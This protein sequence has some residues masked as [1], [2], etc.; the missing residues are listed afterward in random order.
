[1][2]FQDIIPSELEVGEGEDVLVGEGE[3]EGE[4]VLVGEGEGE[5]EFGAEGGTVNGGEDN[6]KNKEQK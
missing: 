5:G 6:T 4:G 2:H 3:G 1:M